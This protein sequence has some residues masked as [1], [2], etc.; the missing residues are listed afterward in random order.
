MSIKF[1]KFSWIRLIKLP[2]QYTWISVF[3][4]VILPSYATEEIR[5]YPESKSQEK[6]IWIDAGANLSKFNTIEKVKQLVRK[7]KN[8]GFTTIVLEVKPIVGYTIYPSQYT[9]KLTEWIPGN[10]SKQ[11][12]PLSFD[13]LEIFCKESKLQNMKLLASLNAFSEGHTLSHL[14]PSG[15]GIGPG[16]HREDQQSV[17]L[18]SWPVLRIYKKNNFNSS[19][20]STV[21]HEKTNS[22]SSVDDKAYIFTSSSKLPSLTSSYT[23]FSINKQHKIVDISQNKLPSYHPDAFVYILIKNSAA[24]NILNSI[25]VGDHI[26]IA[27]KHYTLPISKKK[28]YQI[29]LMMNPVNKNV[30]KNAL[31]FIQE[32][33]NKYPVDGIIYDDRLRY[34]GEEADFSLYTKYLFEDYIGKKINWDKDIFSYTYSLTL[35]RNKIKGKY[36]KEW[37]YWRSAHMELFLMKVRNM[38]KKQNPDTLFGIYVGGNFSEYLKYGINYSSKKN[39]HFQSSH[40]KYRTTGIAKWLD[41]II[42]GYYYRIPTIE[43]AKKKK[44]SL[45]F[46]IESGCKLINKVIAGDTLIY[47]GVMLDKFKE[48][49]SLLGSAIHT[50]LKYCNGVMIFDLSHDLNLYEHIISKTFQ[51]HTN[52]EIEIHAKDDSSIKIYSGK[53]GIGF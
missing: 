35:N 3:F 1:I 52:S 27:A 44:S 7:L 37:N 46:T 50:C 4:L 40:D 22:Y 48:N 6:I 13:P 14:N 16:Y 10:K 26:K 38:I 41:F 9:D 2:I 51:N 49:P 17:L 21:L 5:I 18:E 31:K 24:K 25:A 33:L 47:P 23:L 45:A 34:A 11:F 20:Y 12:L 42:P 53:E 43:L 39:R 28:N 15:S 29:P 19:I 36:W 32:I 30:Q 8:I